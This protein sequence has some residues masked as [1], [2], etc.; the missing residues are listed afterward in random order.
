[1]DLTGSAKKA[2]LGRDLVVRAEYVEDFRVLK[3]N[4]DSMEEVVFS[5]SLPCKFAKFSSFLGMLMVGFKKEIT[6]LLRKMEARKK[7]WS[8]DLRQKEYN[9][10]AIPC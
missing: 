9:V 2:P 3:A 6:S 4:S 1:M 7:A 5:E 10:L 8:K